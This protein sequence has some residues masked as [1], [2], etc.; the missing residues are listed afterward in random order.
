MVQGA[1]RV[2]LGIVV[3]AEEAPQPVT[4]APESRSE[5]MTSAIDHARVEE[6]EVRK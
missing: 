4:L 2:S 6:S 1:V 3:E 5:E